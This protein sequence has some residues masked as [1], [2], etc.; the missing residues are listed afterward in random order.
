MEARASRA[1]D[2]SA[3]ANAYS[4]KFCVRNGTVVPKGPETSVTCEL[5]HKAQGIRDGSIGVPSESVAHLK[6]QEIVP[7]NLHGQIKSA[8]WRDLE[9]FIPK[10]GPREIVEFNV[11]YNYL[12][13]VVMLSERAEQY[14]R[15]L[16]RLR[17]AGFLG[18]DNGRPLALWV[19]FNAI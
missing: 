3:A 11:V 13:S 4:E 10:D 16:E 12:N 18:T 9:A 2:S 7:N 6:T 19:A 17:W 15:A 5:T 8:P 1:T 14:Q